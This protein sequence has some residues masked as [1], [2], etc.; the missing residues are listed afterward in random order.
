MTW[1]TEHVF[2]AGGEFV[3]EGWREFQS[4]TDVSAIITIADDGPG[5]FTDPRPWAWLWL[6]VADEGAYTLDTL[7]LGVDF[8]RRALAAGRK[9]LLHGPRGLHRARPLAAAHLLAT[10]RSLAR[11]LREVERRPWLPPY[12]GDPDLLRQFVESQGREA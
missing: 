7:A 11:V 1:V 2:V 12:H 3:V 9:V 10:G 6:P 5:V 4:Q 8:I